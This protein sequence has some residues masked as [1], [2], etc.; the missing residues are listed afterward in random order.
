MQPGIFARTFPRT[1]VEEVFDA[2]RAHGLDYTQF[3]MNCAGLP[4]M[5]DEIGPEVAARVREAAEE[6]GINIAAVSG[7][8][9]MIHPDEEARRA[10]LQRLEVLAASCGA[11]DTFTIT[12]CTGTRD[13]HDMW[14]RHPGND[15]PEAWR[16][17][18]SSMHTALDVAEDHGVTLA[19]EPE[20]GNV[21]S[22]AARGRRLLDEM[23]S[24]RLKVIIDAANLVQNA[25]PARARG[26]LEEAFELLGADV[27]IAHAKDITALGEVVAAGKGIVDY[28]AYLGLL[29]RA[30]FGG[31]VVLHG[32]DETEVEDSVGFLRGRLAEIW[33]ER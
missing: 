20:P 26:A 32:L 18:L 12:L 4:S 17:L 14:R 13:P 29:R 2:V 8:F 33:A 19:F 24:T 1:S 28:D 11:L 7:T 15:T 23:G 6:R 31:P 22:S 30:G 3:N 10:G 16:D 21:V 25:V 27:V 5:P 9:N